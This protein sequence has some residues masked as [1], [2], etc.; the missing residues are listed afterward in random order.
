MGLY[1]LSKLKHLPIQCG[2]YKDDG[3]SVSDLTPQQTENVK[4]EICRIFRNLGLKITIECNKK[5]VNFLDVTLDLFKG[6]HRPFRKENNT[7]LYVNAKSNH[8]PSVKKALPQNVNKRLNA[9][10]S[11]EMAFNN[12]APLYHFTRTPSGKPDTAIS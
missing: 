6:E 9:L 3:I 7:P 12:A 10:S 5:V 11:N 4:K 2:I 8:P 1:I